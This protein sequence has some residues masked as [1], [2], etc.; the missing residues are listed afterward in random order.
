[1]FPFHVDV[2]LNHQPIAVMVSQNK[3]F[4]SDIYNIFS[5]LFY[6]A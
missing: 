6:F 4:E 1:M 2:R 5:I 3:A